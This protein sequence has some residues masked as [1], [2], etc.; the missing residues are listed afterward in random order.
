MPHSLEGGFTLYGDHNSQHGTGDSR[1]HESANVNDNDKSI[2][3]PSV[4]FCFLY[5]YRF[6][7]T[8]TN[9]FIMCIFY[10][11]YTYFYNKHTYL[12]IQQRY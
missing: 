5:F 7:T 4:T 8:A 9:N 6:I 10:T 11:L 3:Y 12:C 1:A 2:D